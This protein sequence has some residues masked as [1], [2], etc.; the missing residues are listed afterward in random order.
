[1]K[2]CS[3]PSSKI[4]Q[5][6]QDIVVLSEKHGL[7]VSSFNGKHCKSKQPGHLLQICIRRDI[8]DKLVYASQPVGHPDEARQPMSRWIDSN[9]SKAYGQARILAR[10]EYFMEPD[11]VRLHTVSADPKFHLNR[12]SFQKELTELL[13]LILGDAS[14]RE[15]AAKNIYGGVLPDR[16][17]SDEHQSSR[18]CRPALGARHCI[19]VRQ[20]P[21]E[22]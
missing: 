21:G 8:V 4:D 18:F 19:K 11:A 12:E 22:L 17:T 14:S 1:L 20:L 7:D 16:W 15:D 13:S 6:I 2:T 5:V 3:V 9:S 10:P